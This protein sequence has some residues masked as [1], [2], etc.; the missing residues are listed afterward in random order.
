VTQ[1]TLPRVSSRLY[2]EQL[3]TL[4]PGRVI[5]GNGVWRDYPSNPREFDGWLKANAVLGSVLAVGI[6]AM[7]LAGLYS[8]GRPDGATELSSVTAPK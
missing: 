3:A 8:A 4:C 1:F 6:M 2:L 5:M 7:A